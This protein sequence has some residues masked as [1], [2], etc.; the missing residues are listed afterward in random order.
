[1]SV[2]IYTDCHIHEIH[3][4]SKNVYFLFKFKGRVLH[5]MYELFKM[6]VIVTYS[7]TENIIYEAPIK[8]EFPM[9]IIKKFVLIEGLVDC[10]PGRG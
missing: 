10:Y 2:T 5:T 9:E 3:L 6:V 8:E 4:V 7:N 1:M